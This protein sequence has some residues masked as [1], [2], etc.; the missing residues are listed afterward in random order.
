[1]LQWHGPCS[2][3][4]GNVTGGYR[5]LTNT[6]YRLHPVADFFLR[7][8]QHKKPSLSACKPKQA[9]HRWL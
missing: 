2:T 8:H 6:Y 7:L 3:G 9:R 1:M 5:Y 4:E